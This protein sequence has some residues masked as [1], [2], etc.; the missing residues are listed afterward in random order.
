[1]E[2]CTL[3]KLTV[4]RIA[5]G[6]WGFAGGS[7]WGP[8]EEK[9]SVAV[10]SAALSAG[11]NFFENAQAY[12]DG[13]SEEVLGRALKGRRQQAVIATKIRPREATRKGIAEACEASLRRLQTDYIDLLQPHW[14]QRTLPPQET[15]AAY[16]ALRQAGKIREFGVSNY[17]MNDLGSILDSGPVVSN[18]LPYSLLFRAIEYA[19]Q[20]LCVRQ[21]VG[22]LCYSSLLHGILSGK[23]RSPAEVPAGR[24][25]TRH[26]SSNRP[27]VRHSEPGCETETFAAVDQIR[28]VA[29]GL[30]QPMARVAVGWVLA[31]PGVAAVLAGATRPEQI[32]ELAAALYAPLPA[33]AAQELTAITD[34]VKQLL[35]A[36]PDMWDS[37][38]RFN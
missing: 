4:S 24:A 21:Q 32:T 9:D 29:G 35:G 10:V 19:I 34:P 18:Q 12:G 8:Q 28:Q 23:Y 36:N 33:G 3:G 1:M 6:C 5:L 15:L 37:R 13:Y 38:S 27:Q 7:M 16:E 14:P 22:I 11:I 17:G 25:R 26:F 2:T 30:G 20:P 31:Q